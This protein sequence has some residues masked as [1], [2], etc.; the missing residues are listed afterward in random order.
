MSPRNQL[1]DPFRL[2]L[3]PKNSVIW[4]VAITGLSLSFAAL[5][6]M[7]QQLEA[8]KMLD[9]EWVSHNRIR[10]ISYGID[11]SMHAVKTI[12]D[13]IIASGDVDGEG[14]RLFAKSLLDRHQGI[15]SLMW[16]PRVK[17]MERAA[18]EVSTAQER[19]GYQLSEHDGH[20]TLIPASERAEYFPVLHTAT[21]QSDEIPAGFDLGSIPRFAETL[22]RAREQGRMAASGRIG[23]PTP[24]GDIEY[25]F[26]VASPV[27]NKSVSVSVPTAD[28]RGEALSGFVVGLFRLR[29]LTNAAISLLEP[30]G[31][32]ILI[33]DKMAPVDERFLYLY[34]SRLA[35]RNIEQDNYDG[36]RS[37]QNEH[38][39]EEHIQVA[40][41][42]LAII[43]V[44]TNL[45]RSAEAFQESPWMVLVAGLVFTILLSFYLMRIREN[46]RERSAMEQH[47]V[48]RE[49]LF[50]QMTETV[51]EGFWATTVDGVDLLYFSP[52]YRKILGTAK[53][54]KRPSLLDATHPEDRPMLAEA[55]RCT[56]REGT[57]T[58]VLH[59]ILRADGVLRW[60][61]TRG[62]A[63]HNVDGRIYRLVGFIEDV[64]ENKLANEA[65]RESEAKLRDLFQQSPD[66]IMTVD[67]KG[68]I[69][70]MNRSIPALPAERAVGHNSLALMPRDFRKWYCKSLKKVFRKGA[71]RQFQYS[72]NDGTYWE[73]RIVPIFNNERQVTAAM[74][75]AGD[76]TEKRNLEEQALR[77]ARLASIGVLAAGAAHEINNPNNAIQFNASLVSRA[78]RDITPILQ[79]YFEENGDFA[80]GGQPFSEAHNN[81][82]LLLSEITNNSDRIRRI[83]EN[84]KH[85]SRQDAGE[86]TENVNIQKVLEATIMILHNQI[87]KFTDICTLE[88]PDGLPRVRGNSQQLEQVFINVLLNALQ[89]LPERNKGVH[90]CVA[91]DANADLLSIVIQDEGGGIPERDLGRLTEPFFTTRT[92]TGGTGLGLSISRSIVERHEGSMGFESILGNGT[93]VTI[94]LPAIHKV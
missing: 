65:L 42:R 75:I 28:Q 89:A 86:L 47:L 58:E 5:L 46:I 21:N 69:L 7:R 92:D 66:I 38:K 16:V 55:L 20:Y 12:R 60:V 3:G 50:R 31:V 15:Q 10:A 1:P 61:R 17:G 14:F 59:R 48:E 70:L 8:H 27:F 90:I 53:G 78:W 88:V 81:F 72:A 57:D 33:L 24:Q 23:Y 84:L 43:C 68:K 39:F 71:T 91:F 80:L 35:P 45:F 41:R 52:A 62:F 36:W 29:N 76:V 83:V 79:E 56:G 37:D 4:L 67:V 6:L 18:F 74:V 9:F 30:R 82:T 64:T 40:D 19:D 13:H 25:G 63:V 54:D 77:N 32:E 44:R 34:T 2:L 51:E 87:Q 85:M 22:S 94:R 26:I 11:N 73:G 49:E 93:T